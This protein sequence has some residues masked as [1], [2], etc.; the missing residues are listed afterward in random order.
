MKT[1][2]DID[3][4][5]YK[6]DF[7][8]KLGDVTLWP[9][10]PNVCNEGYPRNSIFISEALAVYSLCKEFD[11]DLLLESGVFRGG[12][13]RIWANVLPD[14][15]IKCIDILE[16]NKHHT[17]VHNVIEHMSTY[18]NIEFTIGDSI[19]LFP[20]IIKNNPNK[21]IGV[22]VDGPKDRLGRSLCDT[23]L[24]YD[25]VHFACLHD[26]TGNNDRVTLSTLNNNNYQQATSDL[27]TNH[28]QIS[29]YPKGPGLWCK[30]KGDP[31]QTLGLL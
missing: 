9:S 18:E 29:Q 28:P 4:V 3:F 21:R 26:Y 1:F 15:D 17:I 16:E 31:I 23:V 22:F 30:L 8:T 20:E 24:G 25:N 5:K 6:T 13:T 10:I 7:T 27:N 12:S 14:I 19:K 2:D 11:I